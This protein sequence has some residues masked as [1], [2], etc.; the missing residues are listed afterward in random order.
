MAFDITTL[1]KSAKETIF[2]PL[3][4]Q[5]EFI[6]YVDSFFSVGFL[7]FVSKKLIQIPSFCKVNTSNRV[8]DTHLAHM[9]QI[10]FIPHRKRVVGNL[11]DCGRC[12]SKITIFQM[13]M[14]V[15]L[16]PSHHNPKSSQ[17]KFTSSYL[18]ISWRIRLKCQ[19]KLNQ[20]IEFRIAKV[21]L[22]SKCPIN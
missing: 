12:A 7:V 3:S 15:W 18:L 5:N 14:C 2:N 11:N 4:Q 8:Q 17:T 22:S 16:C 9:F 19:C 1:L 13:Y 6:L 10:I 20:L 21:R